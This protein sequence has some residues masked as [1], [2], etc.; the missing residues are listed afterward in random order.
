VVRVTKGDLDY[1]VLG[2]PLKPVALG[3]AVL[4]LTLTVVNLLNLGDLGATSF[5]D[6]VSIMSGASFITLM[7]G[8][9][10]KSQQAAEAGLLLAC[11]TYV[12]RSSFLFLTNGPSS[13]GVYLGIGAAIIAGGAYLLEKWDHTRQTSA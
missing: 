13:H 1:L 7:G 5:G 11:I 10:G 12:L 6:L 8:W 3:M 9:I 4:M 2:R